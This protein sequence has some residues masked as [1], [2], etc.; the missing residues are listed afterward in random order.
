[1]ASITIA[2]TNPLNTSCQV[3]DYAYAVSTS[4]SG[5]FETNGSNNLVFIGQIR[6]IN[7]TTITCETGL[8]SATL[9]P[10]GSFILFAKD[11]RVNMS[12]V[13]GYYAETKFACDDTDR[14]E[15][16]SVNMGTFNS[17]K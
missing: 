8:S 6:E 13:L 11:E 7:N 17:S 10:N 3:G 14:A 2:F 16:F 15:L 12:N 9:V 4:S 1:M 5:G